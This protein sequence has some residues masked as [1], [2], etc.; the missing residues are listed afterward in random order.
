MIRAYK[1]AGHVFHL[2]LPDGSPLWDYLDQYTPF[3][4]DPVP[5]PVFS[6]RVVRELPPRP[7]RIVYDA[8]VEP[9]ETVI[10]LYRSDDGWL[11][12]MAPSDRFPVT[13]RMYADEDFK[14][15][16]LC[17]D[18]R[19]VVDAVFCINNSLMLL[20]AFCTAALGTLEMHAS[21]VS[22][23][24]KAFLF[25]A[26]SGTGKST[27]SSLWLKNVPGSELVNDDNPIVR[28]WP[29]GRII[30]YGS[31]W[32]GKTPCYRN[33]EYPVGAFVLIRRSPEN[34]ITPLSMLESYATIYSSCSGFKACRT[35]GDGLHQ[36]IEASVVNVPCYVLDC[37]PD[38]EAAIVCSTEVL[39]SADE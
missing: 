3:G 36:S 9:G 22:N 33:V 17:I 30:V 28:V 1:V 25:L 13:G 24:G 11:F 4:T 5:A 15:G 18:S 6:L 26:K 12:D 29:D 34:K 37:R 14:R 38:R 10:K 39:K 23:S 32:S 27:H 21:V 7:S 2:E 16:E 31:P 8:P 20:Y 35:I 19:K